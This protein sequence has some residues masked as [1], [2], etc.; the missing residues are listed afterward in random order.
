MVSRVWGQLLSK[1]RVDRSHEISLQFASAMVSYLIETEGNH[2]SP[3]CQEMSM[4]GPG[5]SAVRVRRNAHGDMQVCLDIEHHWL[6]TWV[7]V[8][9]EAASMDNLITVQIVGPHTLDLQKLW[10]RSLGFVY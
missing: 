9:G 10:G 4:S 8:P 2:G 6:L 1:P 3:P 5:V 7:P